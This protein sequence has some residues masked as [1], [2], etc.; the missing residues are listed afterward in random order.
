ME[1]GLTD[2]EVMRLNF[3][4]E[5]YGSYESLE[6]AIRY[7]GASALAH[8][9]D[10]LV[11]VAADA[12]EDTKEPSFDDELVAMEDLNVIEN[13]TELL[14]ST[15]DDFRSQDADA[16]SIAGT[17]QMRSLI[18]CYFP[19]EANKDMIRRAFSPYGPIDSVYLVHVNGKPACYGFVNFNDHPSAA[20]ALAAAKAGRIELVDK[21]DVLW[22]VK[23][24]WTSHQEIPKKPKKKR[25]R[26]KKDKF[27][28]TTPVDSDCAGMYDSKMTIR[29][30]PKHAKIAHALNYSV[31]PVPQEQASARN[32]EEEMAELRAELC[33]EFAVAVGEPVWQWDAQW[34]TQWDTPWDAQWDP[35]W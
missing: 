23:A 24:E 22:N 20:S 16:E 11:P 15:Y 5:Y 28:P 8:T 10:V 13:I 34:D 6:A 19:R 27:D 3:F 33:A 32:Y 26:G 4:V 7:F 25:E 9:E 12:S 2:E 18:V 30:L 35:M 14:E 17:D 31:P 1:F 29:G 21:R